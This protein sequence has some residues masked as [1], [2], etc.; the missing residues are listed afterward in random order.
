[1]SDEPENTIVALD[2]DGDNADGGVVLCA[3]ADFYSSPELSDRG[4]LAWTEWNHPNLP[5]DST[6][7]KVGTLT[8]G[9]VTDV[10]EVAGGPGESAVVPRWLGEELIFVSD[11]T[12]WWNLYRWKDGSIEA[13]HATD[14]EFCLP[15]WQLGQTPYTVLDH[16]QLLCS[17]NR[18]GEQSLA[19]LQV[20][21]GDLTPVPGSQVAVYSLAGGSGVAA[22]ILGHPDRPMTLSLLDRR[23]TDLDRRAELQ[24][25]HHRCRLRLQGT[26]RELGRPAG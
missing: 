13:L 20:S 1:M 12:D 19:V 18:G 21:S 2:L 26:R 10:S 3:G 24:P 11:R 22:A 25:A 9:R 23:S 15:Q 17:L 16:D 7:I 6:M 5:W 14:A 8:E 4:R